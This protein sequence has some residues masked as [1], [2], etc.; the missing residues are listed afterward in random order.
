MATATAKVPERMPFVGTFLRLTSKSC[1]CFWWD[2]QLN[3]GCS[4]RRMEGASHYWNTK[5]YAAG[6]AAEADEDIAQAYEETRASQLT[7]DGRLRG[8]YCLGCLWFLGAETGFKNSSEL[9]ELQAAVFIR[10]RFGRRNAVC[11]S[12]AQA[13]TSFIT[14]R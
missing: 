11:I 13:N 10:Y 9:P 12:S 2:S 8:L 4:Y 1:R 5:G 7:V 14:T 6:Q 3:L